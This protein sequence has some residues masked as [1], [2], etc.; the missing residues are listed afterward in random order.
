MI[1]LLSMLE[2]LDSSAVPQN[3]PPC[4]LWTSSTL[5]QYPKQILTKTSFSVLVLILLYLH[6]VTEK[7]AQPLSNYYKLHV[8]NIFIII[9]LHKFTRYMEYI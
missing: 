1:L 2:M 5:C 6:I 9:H 4:K 7:K 8:S 3:L